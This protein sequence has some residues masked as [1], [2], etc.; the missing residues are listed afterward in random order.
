VPFGKLVKSLVRYDKG[1]LMRARVWEN[2][3][4]IY[5]EG[6]VYMCSGE[7]IGVAFWTEIFITQ[8]TCALFSSRSKS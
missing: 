5:D 7:Y 4:S 8:R 2:G 1:S 6:E 3:K